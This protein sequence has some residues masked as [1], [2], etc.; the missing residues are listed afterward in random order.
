MGS[1]SAEVKYVLAFGDG[2]AENRSVEGYSPKD[3]ED[4]GFRRIELESPCGN[5][6]YR[7]RKHQLRYRHDG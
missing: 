1:V 5:A 3:P 6:L 2:E 7:G 4:F